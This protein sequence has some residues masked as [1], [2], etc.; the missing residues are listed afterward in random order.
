[1]TQPSSALT[2]N[3]K[4]LAQAKVLLNQQT[5]DAEP[6]M[7]KAMTCLKE[8]IDDARHRLKIMEVEGKQNSNC[9]FELLSKSVRWELAWRMNR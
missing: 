1:M 6:S 9:Y 8:A 4:I 5:P 2:P 3:Q 7:L